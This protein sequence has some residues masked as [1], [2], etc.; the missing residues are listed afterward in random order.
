[1]RF[2]QTFK[3]K[4]SHAMSYKIVNKFKKIMKYSYKKFN[5]IA[6]QFG[7]TKLTI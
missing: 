6:N 7:A 1:M 3:I 4:L 5:K 2:Y